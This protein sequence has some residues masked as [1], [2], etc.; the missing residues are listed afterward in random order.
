MRFVTVIILCSLFLG[1][2]GDGLFSFF[3]EAIQGTWDLCRAYRDNLRANHQNSDQYFYARGNFEAQQRGSGG[4]WAA[5]II[6]TGRKYFQGLMNR[7]YFGIRD[8]GLESLQS[9]QKAEEWGRS[10]K[11]PNHFR[12]EGLPE[13]Y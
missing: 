2:S 9:T 7:Y 4:V 1:V 13:K 8:H 10:G 12:P 6:S 11:D 5:K 3:K